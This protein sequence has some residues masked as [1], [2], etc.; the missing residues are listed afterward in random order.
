MKLRDTIKINDFIAGLLERINEWANERVLI[1]LNTRK[2]ARAVRDALVAAGLDI[3]FLT[4]DI[5]PRDRLSTIDEIKLAKPCIVVATQCVEAGVDIDMTRVIR[6]FAPLDSIVQVAGRCNRHANRATETIEIV[7]L[8]NENGK[9]FSEMVYD[10]VLLQITRSVLSEFCDT[11][12]SQVLPENQILTLTTNYFSLARD[13]NTG[14]EM[15]TEITKKFARWED[16]GD[17]HELLRGQKGRQIA[18]VVI[19]QEPELRDQLDLASLLPDRWDKR[20]AIRKLANQLAMITVSIYAN[21]GIAPDDF[22]VLDPTGNFLLLNPGFYESNRGIDLDGYED[23]IEK[24]WGVC[25]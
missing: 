3:M 9:R 12:G 7:D 2:S 20:R 16:F 11:S 25:V 24:S 10:L 1:I 5:T 23:A 18:F 13:P 22:A 21:E 19:E 6:D 17:V 8:V 14:K 15:G 4:A